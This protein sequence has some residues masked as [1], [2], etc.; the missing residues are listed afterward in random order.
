M[1]LFW[2]FVTLFVDNNAEI[3]NLGMNLEGKAYWTH[4][5]SWK[6]RLM[7]SMPFI[8]QNASSWQDGR[9]LNFDGNCYVKS[10]L[11]GQWAGSLFLDL[12]TDEYGWHY[13]TQGTR[14]FLYD[15]DCSGCDFDFNSQ[16]IDKSQDGRWIVNVS[17]VRDQGQAYFKITFIKDPIIPKILY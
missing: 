3:G 4:G 5:Y 13:S 9:P 15:G 12:D 11:P 16:V 17:Q 7:Q 2:L 1:V 6:N 14:I 8:S 10:L